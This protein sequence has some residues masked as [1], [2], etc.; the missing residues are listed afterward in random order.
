[1]ASVSA[2]LSVGI[3]GCGVIAPL[4]VSA[5][6]SHGAVAQI[7]VHDSDR[8]A[9]A[10]LQQRCAGCAVPLQPITDR[11][12]FFTQSQVVHICT[13]HAQHFEDF[14]SALQ[15]GAHALCEKPLAITPLQL[16]E[17]THL[18]AAA[19]ACGQWSSCI[20]QHRFSGLALALRGALQGGA[21][22]SLQAVDVF[23]RCTRTSAYYRSA[24]W[25][26]TWQGEG[27]GVAINQMIHLL[28]LML[29]MTGGC[30]RLRAALGQRH[31]ADVIEVED[32]LQAEGYLGKHAIPLRVDLANDQ[33]THWL[34]R[35]TL[36]LDQGDICYTPDAG[37]SFLAGSTHPGLARLESE[38]GAKA[39]S[40][41]GIQVKGE[42]GDL[43]AAQ[44]HQW[45]DAILTGSAPA[46]PIAEAAHTAAWVLACYRSQAA[47]Q[48]W[49]TVDD[50]LTAYN[51]PS[52]KPILSSSSALQLWSAE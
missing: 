9:I 28:D 47:G 4:H 49:V 5:L 19:G 12:A 39:A 29:W 2:G 41:Q 38:A 25:R 45:L 43:H 20:F 51:P 16:S 6:A 24:A 40:D 37:G 26:G 10:S 33:Q 27:G 3:I 7:L 44:I 13:P 18:A 11:E 50:A 30:T 21:L 48:A 14:R 34:N 32:C 46:V 22:G 42:Y 15:H 17:M 8:K 23:G 35:L 36:H 52:L 1:M 31:L